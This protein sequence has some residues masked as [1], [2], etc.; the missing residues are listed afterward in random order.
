MRDERWGMGD[1]PVLLR[2]LKF[3]QLSTPI[4]HLPRI[5]MFREK[6]HRGVSARVLHKRKTLFLL[7]TCKNIY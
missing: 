6:P 4:S 2:N 1:D 5:R 3:S 7:K